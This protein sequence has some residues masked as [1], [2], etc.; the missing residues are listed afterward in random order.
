MIQVLAFGFTKY[1]ASTYFEAH[2]KLEWKLE[3][4]C[5]ANSTVRHAESGKAYTQ[6]KAL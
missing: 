6:L 2:S 4:Y 3:E 1:L 5:K